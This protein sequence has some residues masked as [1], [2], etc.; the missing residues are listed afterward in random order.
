VTAITA[1]VVHECENRESGGL[2]RGV[3]SRVRVRRGVRVSAGIWGVRRWPL[4]QSDVLTARIEF[5]Y[6]NLIRPQKR[7]YIDAMRFHGGCAQYIDRTYCAYE[8]REMRSCVLERIDQH[9]I[10]GCF[11]DAMEMEISLSLG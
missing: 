11:L 9:Q 2:R 4:N 1:R 6:L 5:T 7:R 8:F 10:Y 3:E